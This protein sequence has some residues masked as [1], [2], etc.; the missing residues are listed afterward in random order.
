MSGNTTA[1]GTNGTAI[2]GN[3]TALTD[4][5][6]TASVTTVAN[7][8]AVSGN[9]I[10]DTITSVNRYGSV[11]I[12]GYPNSFQYYKIAKLY[13]HTGDRLEIKILSGAVYQNVSYYDDEL[14]DTTM[15]NVQ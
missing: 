8:L 6:Y 4:I 14:T 9:L 13:G 2:S 5:S 15:I 1:I 11:R 12:N 10:T 3:T 7:D